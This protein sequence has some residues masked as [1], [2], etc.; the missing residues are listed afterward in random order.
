[1]YGSGQNI[2][3]R[4]DFHQICDSGIMACF[5]YSYICYGEGLGEQPGMTILLQCQIQ[6][7]T[8]SLQCRIQFYRF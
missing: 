7:M 2:T 5:D 8:I 1:M 6:S 4:P 3:K